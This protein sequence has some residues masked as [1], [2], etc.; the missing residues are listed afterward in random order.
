MAFQFYNPNPAGRFVG[1]CT[2]RAICRLTDKDW[3]S[4]Y[5]GTTFEGF[6]H[7]DMSSGNSTWGAYLDRLGYVRRGLSD[8]CPFRYTVKDFCRDH[9]RGRFLLSL[10]QQQRQQNNPM[11]FTTAL[12]NLARQIMPTGMNPEQI[13]RQKIQNREMT[14]AQFEQYSQQANSIMQMLF[15][16]R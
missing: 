4:V 12:Q 3:D 5:A 13:V 16:R 14:Q 9:P 7:K 1:D 11:D 10:D 8:T 2:I 6:L 15:G